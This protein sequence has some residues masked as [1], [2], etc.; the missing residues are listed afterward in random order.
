[1]SSATR[2]GLQVRGRA[3]FRA[4][5]RV[6]VRNR[7]IKVNPN[8]TPTPT[9]TPNPNPDQEFN[10]MAKDCPW[11]TKDFDLTKS[12]ETVAQQFAVVNSI[13]TMR[14]SGSVERN[15]KG[16]NGHNPGG[17]QV[18]Q[19]TLSLALALPLPYPYPYP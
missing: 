8:P 9:P 7:K 5:V 15:A 14:A 16:K 19:T 17:K 10:A 11:Q 12:K 1:M 6:R 18:K 4:R 3:R 2:I 13:E